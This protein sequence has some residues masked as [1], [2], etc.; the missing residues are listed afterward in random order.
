MKIL[1]LI[2]ISLVTLLVIFLFCACFISSNFELE[3]ELE[4]EKK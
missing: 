4:N 2:V 1:S 3:E